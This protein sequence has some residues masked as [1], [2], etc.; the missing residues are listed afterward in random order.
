MKP[1]RRDRRFVACAVVFLLFLATAIPALAA[2][3]Q[4]DF[5]GDG[6]SDVFWRQSATGWNVVWRSGDPSTE[7]VRTA[8]TD[9]AW[10]VVGAGDFNA[11][12]RADLLWRHQTTGRNAIWASSNYGTQ[13]WVMTVADL[14]W[15][16]AGVGDFDGDG[17]SDIF[18]RNVVTGMNVIWRSAIGSDTLPVARVSDT[19]WVVA[20][21]GD[22][23][24]DRKSDVLWRNTRTGA[25]VV[26]R[27]ADAARPLAVA[28]A[29]LAWKVVGVA[30]FT[31]DG[32]ADVFWRNTSTGADNL[33]KSAT[34]GA[35]AVS[36]V[37]SQD[38]QVAAVG[39]YNADGKADVF[40]RN[41]RT[42]ANTIWISA[43]ASTQQ[44]MATVSDQ[45]W[46][47][48]PHGGQALDIADPAF[49]VSTTSPFATG[50][51]G[52]ATSGVLYPG[53]EV[54]PTF[55]I[56]A[57]DS[58][59]A[60]G[61]WQQDRWS[62]GSSR[63]IV[64]AYTTD[65]GMTW[66]R[67]Q[68]PVSRCGGGNAGNGGDYARATDPWITIAPNGTAFLMALSTIGGSFAT[69]SSNAMLVTRSLDGGRNWSAPLALIHDG[70]GAFNDKNAMTA[71]PTNASLVYAVWDRL[72]PNGNGPTYFTRTTN[73]GQ[74]WETARAIYNPGSTN[75]T[76]GNLVVVLRDGTLLDLFTE[77]DVASDQS[78]SAFFGVIRSVDKGQTWSTPIHVADALAIGARDP[79]TGAAVRD[80]ASIAQAAVAPDGTVYIVWQ[81]ARFSGGNVDGIAMSRS[82]DGGLHWSAPVRINRIG[83]VAAFEPSVHVRGDG[84]IGISYYDFRSDTT[85]TTSLLTDYWLAWSDDGGATWRENRLAPTF[86]LDN[87]PFADGY[88]LGD[89]QGLASRG[90]VFVPFF[91]KA[92]TT[93]SNRTDVFAVP[94]VSAATDA[95]SFR[96]TP[97][98]APTTQAAALSPGFRQRVQANLLHIIREH[99]PPPRDQLE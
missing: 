51:D 2:S 98:P 9:P 42:G 75:Q 12:G 91:V 33:W 49:V 28:S 74:S 79:T 81:D 41:R 23:D 77:I 97:A 54:E 70:A 29:S 58:R 3:A 31:G 87:A 30:D 40:W 85:A 1:L 78:T 22:F 88:F 73:G 50:C 16:V 25:N 86:D 43:N 69:G 15:T 47:P 89:Y 63:G 56:S 94:A 11:D 34:A 95:A 66:T 32:R 57:L 62:N 72:T 27:A 14:R 38:W 4:S 71:D 20:G 52:Q 17:H 39:D 83:T 64:A 60:I 18:W 46:L 26:W 21:I 6:R 5:D 67:R 68:V 19:A 82:T 90:A 65:G 8:V 92:G 35:Q 80:G 24:G 7:R 37:T 10:R 55:A 93:T 13:L 99:V 36:S 44:A 76:I 59:N 48:V 84:T 96:A 61:A 45:V 53:A